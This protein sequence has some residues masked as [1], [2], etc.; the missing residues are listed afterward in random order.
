MK[1][2]LSMHIDEID[3]KGL[4]G[5]EKRKGGG[6]EERRINDVDCHILPDPR[7]TTQ[8]IRQSIWLLERQPQIDKAQQGEE[9]EEAI[10]Y[11]LSN[12]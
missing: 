5:E 3:E 2:F 6:E 4:R 9:E 12:Q 11:R 1:I 10:I 7:R 8:T